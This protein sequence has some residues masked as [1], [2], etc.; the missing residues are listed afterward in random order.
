ME[1]RDRSRRGGYVSVM[2]L[3][4]A[5]LLGGILAAIAAVSRPA[6][7][8]G[9]VG[10][11]ELR[12]D[13]LIEAGLTTAGYLLFVSGSD[14]RQLNG[15]ELRF[16]EGTARLSV[17]EEAGFI[18]L[19]GASEALLAGLYRAVG[20]RSLDPATFAARVADW[21][22]DSD[23]E[24]RFGGAKADDYRRAGLAY[25]P[26]HAPFQAIDE[27]R[28]LLDLSG[29]D[30]Q[31]LAPYLTVFN[32]NGQ[33]DAYAAPRAVLAAVP[34]ISPARVDAIIDARSGVPRHD[35]TLSALIAPH[36]RFL[37]L[38]LEPVF[39]VVS[40]AT[41]PNGFFKRAEVTLVRGRNG[42]MPY[43]TLRYRVDYSEQSTP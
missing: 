38:E 28:L 11:D 34:E 6:I 4:I 5:A 7:E 26:R 22:E 27:L 40:E 24:E 17:V 37:A 25:T 10:A 30:F 1:I 3:V 9:R 31:R 39:R 20:G 14:A 8:L 19:N 35:A 13:G 2:V 21:R 43:H 41:L 15:H 33:V 12:A 42:K 18:D 16:G 29:D 36:A 23:A 32:P